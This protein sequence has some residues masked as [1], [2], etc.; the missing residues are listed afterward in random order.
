MPKVSKEELLK[1]ANAV[2]GEDATAEGLSLLED[3][4]DTIEDTN[5]IDKYV[6][7]IEEL[8]QKV[9][10]TE[11]MWSEKYRARF[12]DFTPSTEPQAETSEVD[13]GDNPDDEE[14]PTFEE[15]ANM[16]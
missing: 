3:I 2:I 9:T 5:D 11:K 12:M 4:A 13:N 15:I 1:K 7:E 6:K 8:K 10:D 16:F 14:P